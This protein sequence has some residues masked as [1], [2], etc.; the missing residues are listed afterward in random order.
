MA[1]AQNLIPDSSFENNKFVPMDFSA[2][3]ASNSWSAPSRGT[4]DL[5]CKCDRKTKLL[6][7]KIYSQVDVPQNSMG[8]QSPHSGTCYAGLFVFSH[9][10]YR[11]YL[12]TALKEPLVKNRSYLFSIYLSLADYSQAS[13]DQFG[14]CFLNNKAGYNSSDVI[15]DLNPI[16]INIEH[17]IGSDVKNWHRI[18]VIYKSGG[19]EAY[20]LFGSFAVNKIKKTKLKAP[21][22]IKSRINQ[23]SERES[24]YFIDDVSL[25]E[26]NLNE[27][28]GSS[29]NREEELAEK[30]PSDSLLVLKNVLFQTNETILLPSSYN[31]L[32]LIA[33]HLKGNTEIRIKIFGHTDNSGEEKTNKKLS[34][35]RAKAVSD[36]L[37]SKGIYKKRITYD[38]YGSLKPVASNDTEEGKQQNRRV[39]FILNNK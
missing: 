25:L 26:I 2:I 9:W 34:I 29:V 14:V 36:Y 4:T 31:E 32:D 24:Y 12:Q 21:K 16:Y 1:K 27:E 11:E 23:N 37:A 8:N 18:E 3:N 28:I 33:E 7:E 6:Q 30:M 10:D 13:I 38:G 22:E 15:T 17:E 35:E 20:L 19:G 5:F 39:E